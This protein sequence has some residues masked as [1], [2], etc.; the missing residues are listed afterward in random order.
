MVL[1]STQPLAE[2]S[3]RNACWGKGDRC[4]GLTIL[5]P[6]CA[7][8]LEVLGASTSW[9]PKG[10]FRSV[11]RLLYRPHYVTIHFKNCQSYLG[12]YENTLIALLNVFISS[13]ILDGSESGN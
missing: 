8:Y 1:E 9:N 12:Y 2:M 4:V 13:V 11:I 6:S 5:T 7:D 3:T 10:L